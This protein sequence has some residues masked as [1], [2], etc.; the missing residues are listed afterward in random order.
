MPLASYSGWRATTTTARALTST[1]HGV[2]E[3][4]RL[5]NLARANAQHSDARAREVGTNLG[6]L[7]RE[8]AQKAQ[9]NR[10]REALIREIQ[11]T[12]VRAEKERRDTHAKAI[13]KNLNALAANERSK[14]ALVAKSRRQEDK[15][16]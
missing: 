12:G 3:T 13:G 5:D 1:A 2:T 9:A 10:D 11:A 16:K 6:A 7:S 15:L 8:K 4:Q 14:A